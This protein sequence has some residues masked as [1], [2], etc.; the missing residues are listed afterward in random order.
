MRSIV[1]GVILAEVQGALSSR[2]SNAADSA[3]RWGRNASDGSASAKP[4]RCTA[5]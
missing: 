2:P 5:T 3:S 4:V 1:P